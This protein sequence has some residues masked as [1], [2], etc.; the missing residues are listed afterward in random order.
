MFSLGE[1]SFKKAAYKLSKPLISDD[2]K[3]YLCSEK[4]FFAFESNGSVAW[5]LSLSYKCSPSMAPVQGESRKARLHFK[6]DLHSY[7]EL[8]NLIK[9]FYGLSYE[10]LDFDILIM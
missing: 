10:Q 4:N 8:V 3:V 1:E 7:V 9:W 5:T 6:T 2:G